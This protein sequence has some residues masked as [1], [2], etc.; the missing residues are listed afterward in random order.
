MSLDDKYGLTPD[1]REHFLEHG[2]VLL[3]GA[4]S[5]ELALN[6]VREQ[7]KVHGMDAD[8]P[9]TWREPR[10]SFPPTKNFPLE[11][12]APRLREVVCDVMGE[13]RVLGGHELNNG[14]AAACFMGEGK[15]WEAP[16]ENYPWHKDGQFFRHFLDSPE[17][18]VLSLPL[19]SDVQ[20]HGG[21]TYIAPGSHKFVARFLA[22]HPEGVHPDKFPWKEL[23]RQCPNRIEAVGQAGDVYFM[24]G[25]MLHT[26]SNNPNRKLRCIANT[27]FALKE[28]MKFQRADGEYSLLEGAVLRALGTES[29]DFQ[30]TRERVR[31]PDYTPL[32]KE[33]A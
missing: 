1:E 23:I 22:E 4:F 17:Q 14:M 15:P 6:E 16:D 8:A 9:E 26:V 24:H 32:P 28:P 31:T 29:F 3:K 7:F 13:D 27:I 20:E 5:R 33:L 30:P 18:A 12:F 25:Y 11:E 21:G 10:M 2:Y 19:W